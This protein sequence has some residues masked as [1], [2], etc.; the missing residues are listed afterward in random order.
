MR[1]N[2]SLLIQRTPVAIFGLGGKKQH[3][4]TCFP[5]VLISLL[6]LHQLQRKS[7]SKS[8]EM[9][10]RHRPWRKQIKEVRKH[11]DWISFQIS[12]TFLTC[13]ILCI[14]NISVQLARSLIN[15]LYLPSCVFKLK[16]YF[17]L[18][19]IQ[20]QLILIISVKLQKETRSPY[21]LPFKSLGLVKSFIVYCYNI[22]WIF[23]YI[24]KCNLF[25]NFLWCKVFS[26]TCSFRNHS[27]MVICCSRNISYYYQLLKTVVLLH[28]FW[29]PWYIFSR[30]FDE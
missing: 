24:L 28:I 9:W 2:L 29:K 13:L 1:F 11:I 30:L 25:L 3:T 12:I 16:I 4:K 23:E 6:T 17:I 8:L 20:R 22:K 18:F 26:V 15:Q 5:S 27:N 21:T 19:F 7:H 14:S 10:L